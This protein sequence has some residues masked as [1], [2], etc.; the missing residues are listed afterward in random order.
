MKKYSIIL[1]L[2]ILALD[3]ITKL[4]IKTHFFLYESK[5]V[6][7]GFFNITYVLNPGAAFGF[8]AGLPASYRK[9]FFVIVTLIAIIIIL[10]LL[11]KES[12]FKLRLI[13]Y[14]M[15]LSGAVGNFID[16]LYIGKVIDFLDFYI[17]NYHWPAFNVADSAISVGIFLLIVDILFVNKKNE[18]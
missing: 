4:Y 15:I 7:D 13:S 2:L 6:I 10:R 8:L 18:R 3:Q 17:K 11:I 16:R 5:T 1:F 9:V 12:N 14:T